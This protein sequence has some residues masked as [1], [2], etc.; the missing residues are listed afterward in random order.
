MSK[1]VATLSLRLVN[2]CLLLLQVI[3]RNL[4]FLSDLILGLADHIS[5]IGLLFVENR[6]S[7]RI[8]SDALALIPHLSKNTF[9][10]L[11][12]PYLL[13]NTLNV[14]LWILRAGFFYF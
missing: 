9:I 6:D 3:L 1:A 10:F 4:N 5:L 12:T 11:K 8:E 13:H 2:E 7:L 14:S